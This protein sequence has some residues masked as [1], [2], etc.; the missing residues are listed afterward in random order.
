MN[1]VKYFLHP[2][3]THLWNLNITI[4]W[5]KCRCS[6]NIIVIFVTATILHAKASRLRPGPYTTG[7]S[8][9]PANNYYYLEIFPSTYTKS[10][11]YNFPQNKTVLKNCLQIDYKIL[12][13][14][15]RF[16]TDFALILHSNMWLQGGE[17]WWSRLQRGSEIL[18]F[19]VS[20]N[21]Q[22]QKHLR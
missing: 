18:L 8:S 11:D 6:I 22:T 3:F 12:L 21:R 7:T 10:Q 20:S 17:K 2:I 5:S 4:W 16:K 13:Q 15:V 1:A 9:E 19:F 14:V